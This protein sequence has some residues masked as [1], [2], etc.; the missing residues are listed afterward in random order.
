MNLLTEFVFFSSDVQCLKIS[1]G[2]DINELYFLIEN[3]YILRLYLKN[4]PEDPN[5]RVHEK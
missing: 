2:L 5:Q 4:I 1:V 3:N